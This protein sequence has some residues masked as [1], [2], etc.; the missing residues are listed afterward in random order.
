VTDYPRMIAAVNQM[1][2]A[3]RRVRAMLGSRVVFDTTRAIYLWE[4]ANYPQYYIPIEDVDP[5]VLVDEDHEQKLSRG[6]ARRLGLRAGGIERNGA[7]RVYTEDS[8]PGLAGLV[9]FEWEAL[10]A[11]FEEDEEI[12]VHPRNPYTRVDAV[13]STRQIRVELDGIVLAESPSPVMVFETGLPTRYY[14]NRTEV[15]FSLLEHTDTVT[16]CP[17]KGSTSDYWS[18]RTPVA[19]YPDMAWSYSFP[20]AGMQAIAGLVSFYNE[21]IDIILDGR[22]LDRPVTHF[23]R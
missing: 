4:W 21:K 17:Y 16:S 3:P 2:P 1:E 23:F 7:A 13:R 12:F 14:L 11:W 18:I 8:L 20:T 22:P 9:R 5:A 10:D 15:D 6:K 19:A